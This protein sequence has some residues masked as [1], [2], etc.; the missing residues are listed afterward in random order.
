MSTV[1]E[2]YKKSIKEEGAEER[3][4]QIVTNMLKEHF[5][6]AKIAKYTQ[7]SPNKILQIAKANNIPVP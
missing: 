6:I 7:L 3:D 2:E 4:I 5:P 1:I